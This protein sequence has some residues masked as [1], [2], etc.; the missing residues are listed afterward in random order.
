M[1]LMLRL[2]LAIYTLLAITIKNV[3]LI[4]STY[5]TDSLSKVI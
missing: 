5:L 3:Y 4:L 1:N 2:V